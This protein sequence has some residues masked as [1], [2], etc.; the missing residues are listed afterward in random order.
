MCITKFRTLFKFAFDLALIFNS[1]PLQNLF[2]KCCDDPR[3]LHC[4]LTSTVILVHSASHSSMLCEVRTTD[5]PS[6]RNLMMK[7]HK[8]RFVAG[9]IPVVGSSFFPQKQIKIKITFSNIKKSFS[10]LFHAMHSPKNITLEFPINAK[11][12][13]SFRLLPPLNCIAFL[14]M[15]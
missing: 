10:H 13:L 6:L 7:F 12:V 2:F 8:F 3:H 4:P 9:S 5:L 11:A 1:N 14:S 15:C